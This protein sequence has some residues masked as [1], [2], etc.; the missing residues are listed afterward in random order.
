MRLLE[1]ALDGLGL[2]DVNE[3]VLVQLRIAS[4]VFSNGRAIR[5]G[6]SNAPAGM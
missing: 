5:S 2:D 6:A 1:H 3:F 4:K